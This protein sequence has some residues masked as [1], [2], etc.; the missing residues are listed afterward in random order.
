[1]ILGIDVRD[2]SI[3]AV[4]ID[5]D[6]TVV[7]RTI[8]PGA[9]PAAV[10]DAIRDIGGER[11]NGVGVA[12]RDPADPAT[13]DVVAAAAGAARVREA[14]RVVTRGAALALA[15]QWVGAARGLRHVVALSAT[16]D[17]H[18]GIV[19]DGRI[20][21]GAHGFAGAAG[22]LAL[23]P[24]ERDDYHRLGCFAAE[25]GR[26]AIVR[27]LVWRIKAGDDSEVLELAGGQLADIAV[28]HVLDAARRG[29]GVAIAVVRDTARYIGMAISNFVAIID[30][31]VVVLGGLIAEAADLLLEP[32][33]AE[34]ARRISAA[35]ADTLQIVPGILG[36]EAPAL[37]A[38]RA[39]LLDRER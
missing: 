39:A 38:A 29:D 12:V 37:G 32:S 20:F 18:A 8:R 1:V 19:I 25:V 26:N 2:G 23:N 6:G 5:P 15:E 10:V 36:D 27:K 14:P 11:S 34:A 17:I 9:T 16:D 22:W 13:T 30:P 24:V 35:A 28:P 21:G 3:A 33:R 4:G 31:D 7:A